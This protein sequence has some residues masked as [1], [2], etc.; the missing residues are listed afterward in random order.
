[1]N[2]ASVMPVLKRLW[3]GYFTAVLR[4]GGSPFTRPKM[5]SLS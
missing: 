1:M 4:T 3:V 5:A 2:I